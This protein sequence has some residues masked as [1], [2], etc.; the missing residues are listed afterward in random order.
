MVS[1]MQLAPITFWELA[2]SHLPEITNLL[3][4]VK[5]IFKE[6]HYFCLRS[7]TGYYILQRLHEN[8]LTDIII[9]IWTTPSNLSLFCLYHMT[10]S[11]VCLCFFR[12]ISSFWFSTLRI[13]FNSFWKSILIQQKKFLSIRMNSLF[14]PY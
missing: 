14:L 4:H 8:N 13:S 3:K 5:K 12:R 9:G 2:H 1:Q 11:N 6:K 7:Y 10:A